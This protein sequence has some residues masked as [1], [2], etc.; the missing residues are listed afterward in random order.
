MP[1]ER[2][3]QLPPD[4]EYAQTQRVH[5]L[6]AAREIVERKTPGG[7]AFASTGS[8]ADWTEVIAVA[9]YIIEGEN[10]LE[11]AR[12]TECDAAE[13]MTAADPWEM[14]HP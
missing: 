5:A 6:R 1:T 3:T 12:D 11:E 9:R 2:W 10:L 4:L 14:T 8:Q 7:A 13:P